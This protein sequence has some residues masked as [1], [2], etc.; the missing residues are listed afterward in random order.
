[1]AEYIERK[2]VFADIS[3]LL[4]DGA[5]LPDY[6][7]GINRA[8][9]DALNII[10]KAPAADVRPERHGRNITK[11]NPVDEFVCSECGFIMRDASGYDEE[12]K[13]FTNLYQS[14]AQNAARRCTER[15]VKTMNETFFLIITISGLAANI[16]SL[17]ISVKILFW[18]EKLFDF[19]AERFENLTKTCIE[20]VSETITRVSGKRG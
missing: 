15:T 9:I 5:I 7:D 3:R 10:E 12:V 14:F 16:I 4:I 13:F 1:M 2:K 20:L 17:L 19:Q 8:I 18:S 6:E 11:M